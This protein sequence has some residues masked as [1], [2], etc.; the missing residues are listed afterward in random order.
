MPT[1]VLLE[2][3]ADAAAR[4]EHA[5]PKQVVA[6]A[7]DRFGDGLVAT[8]SFED[9]ALAHLVAA[10][11]PAAEI[12]FLDTQYHFAETW[13]LVDKLRERFGDAFRL[14]VLR[15][16]ASVRPD[17][18][19]L[20][21]TEGCCAVRKVEPLRRAIAGRS[22]WITGIRRVDGPTRADAPVLQWDE[23]WGVVKINPI[24]AWD[25]DDLAGY[26]L[27]H[28]LPRHP[29]ADRG[30]PSIGCWPCTRPVAEGED[31]RAGRW[32]GSAKTECGLHG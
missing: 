25:D 32:A 2:E 20:T 21:D 26:L 10:N 28:D 12:A 3:L 27:A 22:A 14:A 9:A 18:R 24:V 19:W 31:K 11:A 1:A 23:R 15:P 7:A 13:W 6:W 5:S 4:L 8:V 29:L 30:Y 17:D 16:D